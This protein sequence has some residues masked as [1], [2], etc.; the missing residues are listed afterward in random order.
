MS[1][2]VMQLVGGPNI[3]LFETSLLA[4]LGGFIE[5]SE[6]RSGT[7]EATLAK[8]KP[9]KKIIKIQEVGSRVVITGDCDDLPVWFD[10]VVNE[11]VQLLKLQ[12]GWNSYNAVPVSVDA[13]TS[14]LQVLFFVMQAETPVPSMVPTTRG[15]I[16]I[17]WHMRG[18]DLEVEIIDASHFR[19]SYEDF[20]DDTI[21]ED[22]HLDNLTQLAQI[23]GKLTDRK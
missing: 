13:F 8:H 20:Q 9:R 2:P 12:R 23:I 6:Q 14:A 18:M 19:V 1:A 15:N 21:W 11:L 10:P 3:G 7:D 22:K 5:R 17:E 16:Q 4:T